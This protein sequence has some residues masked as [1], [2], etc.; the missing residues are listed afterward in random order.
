L[1]KL[2]QALGTELEIRLKRSRTIEYS[3]V[4]K[5]PIAIVVQKSPWEKEWKEDFRWQVKFDEEKIDAE[6]F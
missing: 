6:G 2:A 3:K 5:V 1:Q 4:I